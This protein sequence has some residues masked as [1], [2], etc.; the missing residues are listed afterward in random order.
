MVANAAGPHGQSRNGESSNSSTASH[1]LISEGAPSCW[2][3]TDAHVPTG[4]ATHVP[5]S[6]L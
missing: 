3:N 1:Q 6:L 2:K 4:L 5:S